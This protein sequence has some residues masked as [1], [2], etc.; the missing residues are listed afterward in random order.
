MNLA[1]ILDPMAILVRFLTFA[2]YPLFGFLAK[3]GWVG[4]Y[5]VMGDCE[6]LP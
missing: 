3:S 4:L 5:K 2:F 6:G 1:G